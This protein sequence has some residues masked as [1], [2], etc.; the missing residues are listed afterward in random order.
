MNKTFLATFG[1]GLLIVLIVLGSVLYLKQGSHLQPHGSIL[2][3]R[4]Q[5][6]DENNSLGVMD[7][8][9]VNDSD[10]DMVVREIDVNLEIAG[11]HQFSGTLVSGADV[12]SLFHYYPLLGEQY[13]EPLRIRDRIRPHS[14]VDRMVAAR[15]SAPE[16]ELQNRQKVI[17]RVEDQDG[18]VAEL[19]GK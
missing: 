2:K 8:R 15:F 1:G 11:G 3:T 17:V 10:V 14:T 18:P 19:T 12:P 7:V 4:M 9:L 5:P 6:L 16:S 13:N